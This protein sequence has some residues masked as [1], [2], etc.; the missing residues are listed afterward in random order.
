MSRIIKTL[1]S[2][3]KV[4]NISDKALAEI[5][6]HLWESGVILLKDQ[7]INP[8]EMS[9]LTARFGEQII[10]KPGLAFGNQFDQFRAVARVGNVREDGSVIENVN[11]AEYW[12]QD[13][14]FW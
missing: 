10:L 8:E 14:Q 11:Y 3:F 1:S 12:H 2:H 9:N 4:R 6:T 5:K 7:E 13:G